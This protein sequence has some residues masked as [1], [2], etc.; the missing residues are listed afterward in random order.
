M[1]LCCSAVSV[2]LLFYFGS[3]LVSF[4]VRDKARGITPWRLRWGR[5]ARRA[6]LL[7]IDALKLDRI[8]FLQALAKVVA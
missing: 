4:S 8:L 7:F 6:L 1:R 3:G 5:Q 2:L